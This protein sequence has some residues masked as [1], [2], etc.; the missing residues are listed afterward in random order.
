M[1]DLFQAREEIFHGRKAYLTLAKTAAGN[2]LGAQFILFSKE[3]GFAD[4]DL[5]SRTHQAFPRVWMLG[6]LAGE[7]DFDSSPQKI[8][9]RGIAIAHG[10]RPRSSAPPV[11][12]CGKDAGV[13]END[14]IRGAKQFGKIVELP[15]VHAAALPGCTVQMQQA[16]G[17]AVLK[18]HLRDQLFGKVVM[19]IGDQHAFRL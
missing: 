2:Y 8:S 5:P 15:I 7:Q 12:P 17:R 13:V 3:Q 11:Q 9:G 19:E 4:T 18:R 10:L 6:E 16:R 14:Q 1:T